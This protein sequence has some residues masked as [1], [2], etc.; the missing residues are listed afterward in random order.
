[1][2]FLRRIV[3]RL[4]SSRMWHHVVWYA[5]TNVSEES[6]KRE[7]TGSSETLSTIVNGVTVQKTVI[8]NSIQLSYNSMQNQQL[9]R[10]MRILTN[11]TKKILPFIFLFTAHSLLK[12]SSLTTYVTQRPIGGNDIAMGK[13]M[14]P[15]VRCYVSICL[16]GLRKSWKPIT[17][18]CFNPLLFASCTD[19]V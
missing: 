11:L 7:E 19:T 5:G 13:G 8:F 1:M 10:L 14:W 2:R 9:W 17:I 15:V 4:L 3:W 18:T 16:N 12:Q 6:T